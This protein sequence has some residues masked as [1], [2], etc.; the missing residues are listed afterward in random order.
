MRVSALVFRF[1]QNCRVSERERKSTTLSVE[2]IQDATLKWIRNTQDTSFADLLNQDGRKPSLVKQLKLYKD[3]GGLLRCKGRIDNA[4][5]SDTA[6]YPY[7]LPTKH[8]FTTLVVMDAH[9]NLLHSG[10]SSTVAHLRGKYWIPRIRQCVKSIL[11]KCVICRRV[12]GKP[13]P[14]PDPPPLPKDRVQES[15]PF[16]VT[17]VDFAGPLFV[18]NSDNSKIKVYLCLFTCASTRAVHIEIIPNMTE[19]AFILAFRRFASRKSLPKTM[20]S[21]NALTFIAASKEIHEL[22][23]SP[24]LHENLNIFGTKWKFIPKRAPWFGGFWERLIGLT[25]NC[26]KKV[27]GNNC[28]DLETLQTI[29][30]EVEATLNDRPLTYVSSDSADPEPLTPSH[31]LYG[32]RI[33][34]LPYPSDNCE[35]GE[36]CQQPTKLN[37][38]KRM[39]NQ[40]EIMQ[41]FV[42]R[43]KNDY[44]TSLRENHRTLGRNNQTIKVGDVVQIYDDTPR[45]LWKLAV[46]D[47]LIHG[48]DKLV[49]SVKLRT[50]SG[51]TNRPIARLYPLEVSDELIPTEEDTKYRRSKEDAKSKIREWTK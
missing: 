41:H 5:V 1:I 27:L 28:I 24:T 49:R 7:L 17:G 40:L 29:T 34:R 46:V 30:T 44:L 38:N 18:R 42:K 36:L 3:E 2:E 45:C 20:I 32:R 4:P 48:E 51:F 13:Y 22:T 47:E 19:S 15:V 6:K 50:N 37:L 16:S 12:V 11:R 26:L 31:L 43:W 25:K 33:T 39:Q 8:R 35:N 9:E 21:D 10:V 14:I 23:N